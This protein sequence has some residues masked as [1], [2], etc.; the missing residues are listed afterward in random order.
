MQRLHATIAYETTALVSHILKVIHDGPAHVITDGTRAD[1]FIIV[2]RSVIVIVTATAL[3]SSKRLSCRV[4][5]WLDF[6]Y[7]VTTQLDRVYIY[8]TS[9]GR[10]R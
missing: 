3:T 8:G 10:P 7:R 5:H 4:L 2:Y 6:K 9:D 1:I